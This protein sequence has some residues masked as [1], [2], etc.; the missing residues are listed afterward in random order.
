LLSI[1]NLCRYTEGGVGSGT[2]EGAFNHDGSA[3][4]EEEHE[5]LRQ[6]TIALEEY[7]QGC[8]IGE[9]R[10]RLD[11]LWQFHADLSVEARAAATATAAANDGGD[12]DGDGEG[13]AA[14]GRKGTARELALA[15]VLYN[16]WRYY[17]QFLPAVMKRVELARAPAAWKLKD[18][19]K[20]AKWED[21]G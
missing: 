6:V 9:F 19:A 14:S 16:T 2:N 5:G 1:S 12:G 15:N 20:L 13:D 21:R 18:H 4:T 3:L 8:T 17:V 11:L 7:V 10:A